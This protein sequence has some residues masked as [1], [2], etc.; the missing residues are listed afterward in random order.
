MNWNYYYFLLH[1]STKSDNAIS[2]T[3]FVPKRQQGQIIRS[4]ELECAVIGLDAIEKHLIIECMPKYRTNKWNNFE[5]NC[6]VII[7]FICEK[8]ND[9]DF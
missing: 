1:C 9:F 7:N 5:F 2:L 3:L 8:K 4:F 6:S